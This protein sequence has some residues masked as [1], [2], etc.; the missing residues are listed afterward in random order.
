[1]GALKVIEKNRTE[2]LKGPRMLEK[3]RDAAA[4]A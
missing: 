2:I 1:M 4:A 3:S